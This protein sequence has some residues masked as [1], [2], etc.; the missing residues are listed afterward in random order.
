MH[1]SRLP[2]NAPFL[3]SVLKNGI[4]DTPSRGEFRLDLFHGSTLRLL[5]FRQGRSGWIGITPVWRSCYPVERWG[6]IL[7]GYAFTVLW[8]YE[9]V[10]LLFA[11]LV[12]M[13]L[14]M[15]L[16]LM[17]WGMRDDILTSKTRGVITGIR[18]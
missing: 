3:L 1:P 5:S 15:F 12:L 11:M 14:P 18:S 9:A 2:F 7:D 6:L 17:V 13:L 16:D 8:T 4:K 10:S